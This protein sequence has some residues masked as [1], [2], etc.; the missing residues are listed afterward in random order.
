M[1]KILLALYFISIFAGVHFL[2]NTPRSSA[3][4]SYFD[5]TQ[6]KIACCSCYVIKGFSRYSQEN[7]QHLHYVQLWSIDQYIMLVVSMT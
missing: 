5:G 3:L 4:F 7:I 1:A 6:H 2:S